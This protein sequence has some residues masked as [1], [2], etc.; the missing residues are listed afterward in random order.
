MR[1]ITNLSGT[2]LNKQCIKVHTVSST[3]C[4]NIVISDFISKLDVLD[5]QDNSEGSCK[6]IALCRTGI[7]IVMSVYMLY[8][9]IPAKTNK[10]K[11]QLNNK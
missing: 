10:Q 9:K 4:K 11:N 3:K 7:I 5:C 6:Y 8:E 2:V 1:S